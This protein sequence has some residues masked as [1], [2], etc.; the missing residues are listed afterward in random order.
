MK[1][2]ISL[3]ESDLEKLVQ[4]IIKEEKTINEALPRRERERHDTNWRK[5]EFEPYQRESDIMSAFGPY[6]N[7]V[8]PNVVSYLRKNPRRFLQKMVEV[9]GMDKVLDF[10]GYQ[11]PENEEMM[12]GEKWIPKDLKKGRATRLTK[13]DKSIGAIDKKLASYDTDPN[14]PGV[15][16]GSKEDLSKVRALNLSK[17]FKK[18]L[19]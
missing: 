19:K 9:Y 5:R 8:P 15:Q 16:T 4:K 17:T 7:D 10:I 14:E 3:K 6:A 13:G 12:E 2:V 11:Q 1:K 18:G